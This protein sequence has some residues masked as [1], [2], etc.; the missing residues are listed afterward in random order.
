MGRDAL[1]GD[2]GHDGIIGV[3]MVDYGIA[4]QGEWACDLEAMKA[5]RMG[6]C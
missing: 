4:I 5:T 6:R 1:L 2:H 3:P